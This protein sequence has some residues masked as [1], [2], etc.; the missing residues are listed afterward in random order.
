ML[1]FGPWFVLA[2]QNEDEGVRSPELT[3]RSICASDVS[4]SAAVLKLSFDVP[5]LPTLFADMVFKAVKNL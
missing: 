2:L 1:E 5:V 4:P 3:S